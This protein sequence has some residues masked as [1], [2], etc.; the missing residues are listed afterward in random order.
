L[1]TKRRKLR[2]FRHSL[3]LKEEHS[4]KPEKVYEI[5]EQMY[6]GP[7]LELF[8]RQ[9]RENWVAWGDEVED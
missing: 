1:F 6:D 5:I 3:L 9:E 4:K 8:A 7:Y 2:A